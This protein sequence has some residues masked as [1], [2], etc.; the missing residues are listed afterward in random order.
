MYATALLTAAAFLLI[1]WDASR[2]NRNPLVA[3]SSLGLLSLAL[4]LHLFSGKG[5]LDTAAVMAAEVGVGLLLAAGLSALRKTT[6]RP[7]FALGLLT[8]GLAGLLQGGARF[9]GAG[10]EEASLL[11]EL[12][13]DDQITELAPILDRFGVRYERAFPTVSL[14]MDEDLAQVFLLYGDPAVFEDLTRALEGDP[15]N[16]DHVEVNRIVRLTPPDASNPAP[17]AGAGAVLED[18]PL[19]SK[20]WALDAIHA[21]EAHALLIDR[22]PVRKAVV[23][24][25]DTVV[26]AGHEEVEGVFRKS[27]V[28]R[29]GHGHGTHCAGIA[30]AVTNNGRGI[31]SLNWE[32]RFVEITG[33]QVLNSSGMGTIEMIAQAVIDAANDGADVISMS[34]GDRSPTPPRTMVEAVHYAQKRGAVVVASAGNANQDAQFHMP[35][36]I[37]GVITV[38][39]VDEKLRKAS[40]SNTNTSLKRPL[41]A[42]GVN[43][44]SLKPNDAYVSLSGTSMSTPMVSGLIGVM[45]AFNPALSAEEIYDILQQSGTDVADTPRVGRVI[46]AEAALRA[47]LPES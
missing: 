35:S 4:V 12:G 39:A 26:D 10:H 47:V 45:R 15:E 37:D 14:S 29:D 44:L 2:T 9:F 19:V 3:V 16:V 41:A 7:F 23:A 33:Y 1:A 31:A 27:G 11:L 42:P 18:D 46:N 25:V 40:F 43:I 24:I 34:L 30:G 6:A 21:H 13:P 38:S 20:Q 32:G 28:T 17:A 5:L 8:L 22:K 36:N